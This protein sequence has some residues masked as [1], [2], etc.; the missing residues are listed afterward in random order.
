MFATFDYTEFPTVK[1]F[2]DK[3][4][5]NMD[6]FIN[7][8]NQWLELYNNQIDFNF[9]FD[10]KEIG[11]IHPKYCIYMA[12]FIRLLKKKPVQ[13][14]K[15]SEIYLYNKTVFNLLKIIFNIE[16]PVAPVYLYYKDNII[17]KY[18]ILPN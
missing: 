14:L 8:T 10:T 12:F 15:S 16:K 11:I 5:E 3:T 9:V 1:V 17:H 2:F 18:I 13:Y 6:D 4:I 7:F